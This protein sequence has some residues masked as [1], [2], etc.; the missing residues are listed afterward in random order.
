MRQGFS[1]IAISIWRCSRNPSQW[2]KE[3][4]IKGSKI[5]KEEITLYMTVHV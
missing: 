5:G 2:N 1:I 4:E 3:K